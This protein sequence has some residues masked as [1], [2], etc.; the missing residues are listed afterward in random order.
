[1]SKRQGDNYITETDVELNDYYDKVFY[2]AL[3]KMED[4]QIKQYHVGDFIIQCEQKNVVNRIGY[5]LKS[6]K[7]VGQRYIIRVFLDCDYK[8]GIALSV[9][10]T[11]DKDEAEKIFK[12]K[13][14]MCK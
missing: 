8:K 2:P 12:Q 10:H 13:V 11:N 7:I 6:L 3:V 5:K 1:M 9:D 4:E 14:Q